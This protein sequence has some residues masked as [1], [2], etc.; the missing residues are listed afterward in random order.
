M[1]SDLF[2]ALHGPIWFGDDE[3]RKIMFPRKNREGW[4]RS[5]N[6]ICQ[7]QKTT[8]CLKSNIQ[9]V[10]LSSYLTNRRII[11]LCRQM[12]GAAQALRE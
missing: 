3:A 6:M 4:W 10:S 1:V 5:E 2:C 9:T 11:K 7:L 8:H 12:E